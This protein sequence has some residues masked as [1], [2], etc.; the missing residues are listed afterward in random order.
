M[1]FLTKKEQEQLKSLDIKSFYELLTYF[2]SKYREQA[3]LTTIRE[4]KRGDAV[5]LTGEIL[6]VENS[7]F[8]SKGIPYTRI[9]LDDGTGEIKAT[10]WNMPYIAQK[11]KIGSIATVSGTIDEKA[12]VQFLNNPKIENSDKFKKIENNSS[13]FKAEETKEPLTA[14]YKENKIIKQSTIVRLI[15]KAL[16]QKEFE[17]IE[18]VIPVETREKLKLPTL[19]QAI[20]MKHFPK[21]EEVLKVAT[22]FFAF[23][24][25]FIL[26]IYREKEKT[27][28][29]NELAH[30]IILTK[31]IED[32][33][34]KLLPF[35]LTGAQDKVF[36]QIKTD[37]AKDRPMSR[38]VEGDVGSGKTALSLLAVYATINSFIKEGSL[39][40]RLQSALMAPTEVLA[41]Q[42]FEFFTTILKEE[43][44][45]ENIKI[46]LLAKNTAKI[47][48]S[49]IDKNKSTV[50]PKNKIKKYLEEGHV[51]I[52]IGTHSVIQ[53]SVKFKRL[54]CLVID[55]Q[56]R[57]GI[58]QRLNL[59]ERSKGD[60][61]V[62]IPHLLSLSATPIP[63]TLALTV[64]GDLDLS[65]LDELPPGR[66]RAETKV[67][68]STDRES[69]YENLDG[70]L[71]NG[72][73]AYII[74]AKV[75][76]LDEEESSAD[77][78]T[79][80]I[81]N[82]K[83]EYEEIKKRFPDYQIGLLYGKQPKMEKEKVLEKFYL[84]EINILVSTSVVEVGVSVANATFMIIEN[85]ERFGL[86]QLHQLRGRVERSSSESICYLMTSTESEKSVNRLEALS[87]T[88]NGFELAEVDLM[89]RGAGSLLGKKQS[90]MTDIGMEAIK[91]RKLVEIAKEEAERLIQKDPELNNNLKLKEFVD[92]IEFHEE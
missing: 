79:K 74:C 23:Q 31:K 68:N 3:K 37:L 27:L 35:K 43:C 71:K 34:R 46:A 36:E 18:D 53:K 59:I 33:V 85:A 62:K 41:S 58:K 56:H 30:K 69:I 2:P 65:I 28:R 90:G 84:G 60:L 83:D 9:I 76:E 82:V 15:K 88:N 73:Q 25:I 20:L 44:W 1:N 51:D 11:L 72:K 50:L 55:E 13:L 87:K 61:S 40:K 42:H 29:Q 78:A 4:S 54:G 75:E 16:S 86:S 22:K 48:P 92:E 39:E 45:N 70:F 66:K 19:K 47:F 5:I 17:N 91:N 6:D 67:A 64:Y 80:K 38:L 10:W 63:R 24:E 7:D 14:I 26:Q 52:L 12:G 49:K 81:K 77:L 8:E 89:E 57:F 32:R 21:D